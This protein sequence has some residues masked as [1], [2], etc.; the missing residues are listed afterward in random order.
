MDYDPLAERESDGHY[1]RDYAARMVMRQGPYTCLEE[2]L[3]SSCT[4]FAAASVS[5]NLMNANADFLLTNA[6]GLN[7]MTSR[8]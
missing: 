5:L 8:V 1:E 6:N 4:A 3:T 7:R 2:R